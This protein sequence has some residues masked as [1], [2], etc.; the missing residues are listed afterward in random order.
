MKR[1][2]GRAHCRRAAFTLI[3][4]LIVIVVIVL[5]VA[6]LLPSLAYVRRAAQTAACLNNLR[7]LDQ[8]YTAYATGNNGHPFVYQPTTQGYWIPT[9]MPYNNKLDCVVLANGKINRDTNQNLFCP[10]AITLASD[11]GSAS[12]AWGANVTG[13]AR[14]NASIPSPGTTSAYWSF[15]NN[16][17]G[18]YGI[19]GSATTSN[20]NSLFGGVMAHNIA[21]SG[22]M[23]VAGNVAASGNVTLSGVNGNV[24]AGG[25]I[26]A[27]GS[28]G[29][30]TPNTTGI[31]PPPVSS[32][33]N[34][35]ATSSGA[36]TI[37]SLSGSSTLDFSTHPVLVY[38]GSPTIVGTPTVHGKGTL[39]VSG[40]VTI[41][42][43]SPGF[44]IVTVGKVTATNLNESGS[45][46]AGGSI[47]FSGSCAINGAVVTNADI[48][49]SGTL[50]ISAPVG[51]PWGEGGTGA[52]LKNVFTGPPQVV[53]A[54]AIWP[55]GSPDLA[56]DP[57]PTDV[58]LGDITHGLGRFYIARHGGTFSP[59]INAV[60]T[61][62]HA[63]NVPLSKV[64][65]LNW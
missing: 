11:V 35:L 21:G 51:L 15:L 53:F 30:L 28:H 4:L 38:N 7:Q 3:E 46:Y 52:G 55:D 27:S 59:S 32:I 65:A 42:N 56:V 18:S 57:I 47:T 43:S 54:D 45:L 61:D 33:Y 24:T 25:N 14:Y 20:S 50:T 16:Y 36:A 34:Q 23:T 10:A 13:G 12:T 19:D 9:L 60:F 6:I 29:T 63:E 17:A 58:N 31:V 40:N 64:P 1:E 2:K 49:N 62:G 26:T 41:V 5:L 48:N 39:C 22:T 37:G 44:N 8:S